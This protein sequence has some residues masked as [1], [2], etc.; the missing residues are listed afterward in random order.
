MA[1]VNNAL[2]DS[3]NSTQALAR[4]LAIFWQ[5][6]VIIG[7]ISVLLFLIWGALDWIFAGSNP[8]R[9]TRAKNKMFD[10]VFGLIILVLSYLIVKLISA[11]TGLNILN[12]EWPVF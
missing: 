10:G 12:P 1:I 7:G 4:Y 5:V 6:I 2:P 9:L 11:F 3:A 8:E